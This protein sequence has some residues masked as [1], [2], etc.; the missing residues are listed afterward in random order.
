VLENLTAA[1]AQEK[2]MEMNTR[3]GFFAKISAVAAATAGIC[4]LFKELH[5]TTLLPSTRWAT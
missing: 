5:M 4:K 3:R 1:S 2:L